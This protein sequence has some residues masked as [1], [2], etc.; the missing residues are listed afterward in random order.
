MTIVVLVTVSTVA[1]KR[2]LG[3]AWSGRPHVREER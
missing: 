2:H 3:T 1:G